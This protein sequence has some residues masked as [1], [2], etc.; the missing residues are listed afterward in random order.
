MS[1]GTG[2]Q[3][4][5]YNSDH[6]NPAHGYQIWI[7][8]EK[9]GITPRYEQRRF[10]YSHGCQLILSPDARDGSLKVYQDMSL[11]RWI[12]KNGDKPN[13]EVALGR[14]IWIQVVKGN[15]QIGD[16]KAT[17]SDAFAISDESYVPIQANSDSEILVFDLPPSKTTIGPMRK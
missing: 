13:I 9:N 12:L 7:L 8:P 16:Q 1:A 4:S 17:T 10:E 14:K 5:E 6:E 15:I 2:I 3:H 11:T